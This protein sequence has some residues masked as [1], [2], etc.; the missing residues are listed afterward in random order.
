MGGGGDDSW[1]PEEVATTGEGGSDNCMRLKV[2]ESG[3][4]Q[5]EWITHEVLH[6]YK[7]S[8]VQKKNLSIHLS[9]RNRIDRIMNQFGGRSSSDNHGF[10][11]YLHA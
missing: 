2:E 7:G 9:D 10:L 1:R 5:K 8:I 3:E 6:E 4:L 11:Y